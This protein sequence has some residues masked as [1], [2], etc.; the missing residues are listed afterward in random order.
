[1]DAAEA[2]IQKVL[3]GEKQFLV[4]HFQRP[5][6][7]VRNDW[8]TLWRDLVELLDDPDAK[9]HFLGPI[10]SAPARSLP[11]GVEKRLLIDGQ[12]RL[13]TLLVLLTLVRDRARA[14]GQTRLADRIE[15]WI[16]N[17]HDDGLDHYK[18]LP[19]QGEHPADSDRETFIRLVDGTEPRPSQSGIQAAYDYFAAK[20]DR[21]DAPELE[22]LQRTI[23]SKLVLVSIVLD[24]KDNPYRIFESLNGKGRPL[25]QVDLIRNYFFM[26]LPTNEHER[27]Y[28]ECWR[29]MQ[30]RLGEEALREFVRHYLSRGGQVVRE[31]DVYSTLKSTIERDASL[32]PLGYL[33]QLARYAG[34]YE[35]LLHPERAK[36]DALRE[37]LVRLNRLQV[38]VAYPFL[39]AV[40]DDYATSRLSEQSLCDL[41]DVL[42][43][44]IVRRFVVGV[45]THGLNKVFP[46]LYQ[47][48]CDQVEATE[49]LDFLAAVK[50]LL[51]GKRCPR[52]DEFR[53]ALMETRLYAGG[54]R[55]EKV[56]LVLERLETS[57]GH[58]ERVD[59]AML[60]IEHVMPQTLTE[61]WKAELGEDWEEDHE[62]LLDTLGNLTLTNYNAELSNAPFVEKK[63]LYA[64]SHL[65][66]NRYFDGI[67]C[68]TAKAIEQRAE[69]LA[70]RAL[71]LWSYFGPAHGVSHVEEGDDS[72][73]GSIPSR[74]VIQGQSV[75][76]RTWAEVWLTTLESISALGT[77]A[78]DRVVAGIPRIVGFS[79]EDFRRTGKQRQIANGAYVE[80]NLNA[81]TI[82]R[83]CVKAV[84]LAG[85]QPD[86]WQVDYGKLAA[87]GGESDLDA[88]HAKPT[89]RT[90]A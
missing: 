47:Q 42:E 62:G 64:A 8:E 85:L 54:E 89:H 69:V 63:K 51:A 73:K 31:G 16:T 49:G 28:A 59:F 20:L 21:S 56:K 68:W 29:P 13:T 27:V 9:P 72:I 41:L 87:A 12:Q 40:W 80:M 45:P 33:R 50:L 24:E 77:E 19:T 55:R 39:L 53:K 30:Q 71:S 82:Y 44:Y 75:A 5:Y 14:D 90:K 86:E 37:R 66:M 35:A 43:S 38:T 79:L 78:F 4:P 36:S 74:V 67:E 17:R 84:E 7:W 58:K 34:Y 11:E 23:T 25:S 61:K 57:F 18:L 83:Y 65:E 76:V 26:R 15:D 2:K 60:S 81:E 3:E 48:A 10:V 70:E 52:D 22:A 1:M 46:P 6:S 88:G 32:D